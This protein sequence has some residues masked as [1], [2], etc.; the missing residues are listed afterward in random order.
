MLKRTVEVAIL[1]KHATVL[2]S[3]DPNIV[4][5]YLQN[6][7]RRSYL[8]GLFDFRLLF[9]SKK[10][11]GVTDSAE[12]LDARIFINGNSSIGRTTSRFEGV[13]HSLGDAIFGT[14]FGNENGPLV[15]I[16]ILSGKQGGERVGECMF[17]VSID[18]LS[19]YIDVAKKQKAA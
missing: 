8:D 9:P 18:V 16:D 12:V 19:R 17:E 10:N 6:L 11:G 3:P 1:L 7:E 4:L 15:W 5:S 2:L 13:L 14:D